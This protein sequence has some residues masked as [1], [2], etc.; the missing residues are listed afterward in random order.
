MPREMSENEEADVMHRRRIRM[1]DG[2]YMIFYTFG[3]ESDTD[4]SVEDEE[5][6]PVSPVENK[7]HV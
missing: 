4:S 5:A 1:K 3:D 6:V 7:S 2:R